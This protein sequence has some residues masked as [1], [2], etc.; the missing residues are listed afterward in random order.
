MW[1]LKAEREGEARGQVSRGLPGFKI[2]K[3]YNHNL[4][5]LL[6]HYQ[7]DKK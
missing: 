7:I 4:Y 2:F 5:F 3:F 1:D 6:F